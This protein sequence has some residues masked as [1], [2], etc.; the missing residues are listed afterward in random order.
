M[1]SL[2]L[3][4]VFLPLIFSGF[5]Q[6]QTKDTLAVK[7][8]A[9]IS[10]KELHGHLA[11][12]ASDEYGGRGT[13]EFGEEL[14]SNYLAVQFKEMGLPEV[15]G[16]Y[17]QKIELETYQA[18][19]VVKVNGNT[20][21]LL[22]DFV[23]YNASGNDF[24]IDEFVFCGYG[25]DSEK[26]NDYEGVDV[27]GKNVIVFTGEPVNKD[28]ISYVSGDTASF[29]L[30][31]DF[32]TK[33]DLAEEKKAKS[34]F[35]VVVGYDEKM[36][37][38]RHF[39]GGTKMKLKGAKKKED[40]GPMVFLISEAM[41]DD[42]FAQSGKKPEKLLTKINKKGKPNSFAFETSA[43][44]NT[45][46]ES[47]D[48]FGKNVLGYIEGTDLKDELIVLTAHYDHL[49]KHDDKIYNG[50]DD[51]GTGTVGLIEIAEAFAT[52][53]SEGHGPRRSILIMP[54]SGE[55][56]GLLGSKYYTDHP[57]FPLENTVANLNIDMIGRY[58]EPHEGKENYI[59][60][61]GADRLSQELHDVNE[62]A[63]KTYVNID[64][65][66][67]FNAEDDPNNFYYRSDHYNFAKNNVPV[68]FYFSGVHEDY[69]Q[70]TDT[71]EKIEF[72]MMGDRTR[73]VFYTAWHLANRDKRIQL[74]EKSE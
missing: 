61:I 11:I 59:Y 31:E 13:A 12:L 44:I 74:N 7:Y 28:G 27:E 30:Q 24:E 36:G 50:A 37:P 1:N 49:G 64:L 34:I 68:I 35:I 19:G 72:E 33:T 48:I 53:K 39:F 32:F 23:H 41:A 45:K 55:E 54:V 5:A 2:K 66:Y 38:Y 14:A 58:D 17:F 63:N 65:D 20:Y 71:I 43:M 29:K 60:V 16:S 67:T 51:N 6:S 4:L 40:I 21:N 10:E 62:F 42:L 46:S 18:A 57:V 22:D 47:K 26:Y 25:I 70:D 56:K 69:H 73:L 15:Y 3:L 9:T 8:A 52:A